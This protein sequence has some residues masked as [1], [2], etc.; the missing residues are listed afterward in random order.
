MKLSL[1]AVMV[2]PS[3]GPGPAEVAACDC[4]R[5]QLLE[6]TGEQAH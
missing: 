5:P 1:T 4:L 3:A 2:L 6:A